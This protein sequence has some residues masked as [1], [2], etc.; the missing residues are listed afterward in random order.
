MRAS[1]DK[2]I[3]APRKGVESVRVH[4]VRSSQRRRQIVTQRMRVAEK[5]L[6][7]TVAYSI[8][9][10]AT[11]HCTSQHNRFETV[12]RRRAIPSTLCGALERPGFGGNLCINS[13]SSVREILTSSIDCSIYSSVYL[14]VFVLILPSSHIAVVAAFC[15][16]SPNFAQPN[17]FVGLCFIGE[18]AC[19]A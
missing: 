5:G 9:L 6:Q 11:F 17:R 15:L 8:P 19:R 13:S 14:L 10:R 1:C 12:R 2:I 7:M 3:C 18:K 16:T 4:C